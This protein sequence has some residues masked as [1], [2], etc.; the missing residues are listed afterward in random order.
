MV[1]SNNF[2]VVEKELNKLIKT[3]RQNCS[4]PSLLLCKEDS[5]TLIYVSTICSVHQLPQYVNNVPWWNVITGYVPVWGPLPKSSSGTPPNACKQPH[6]GIHQQLPTTEQGAV[7]FLNS[8]SKTQGEYKIFLAKLFLSGDDFWISGPIWCNTDVLVQTY[9]LK[10]DTCSPPE[11]FFLN[12]LPLIYK[13][14]I[15]KLS[16]CKS[17]I[18]L[19]T[20]LYF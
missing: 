4:W 10:A 7:I 9:L 18:I 6:R 15:W 16:C 11:L 3:L 14:D 17:T 2:A 8:L 13:W 19:V 1:P 20:V 5:S 12:P